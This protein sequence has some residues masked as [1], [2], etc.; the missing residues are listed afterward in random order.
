M[1][2]IRN[3]KDLAMAYIICRDENLCAKWP[4]EIAELK[5]NIRAYVHKDRSAGHKVV[6]ENGIDS[7]T[8]LVTIPETCE[9]M[10]DADKWFHDYEYIHMKY[11]A[12]DCTGRPFTSWYKI[13]QR[14]G[15]YM[16]YHHIC[17]DV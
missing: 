11:E 15:Q 10:D 1:F 7:Y 5:R 12:Y 8:V 2:P 3:K 16:A 13:F 14:H 17:L 6:A 4:E 9:S